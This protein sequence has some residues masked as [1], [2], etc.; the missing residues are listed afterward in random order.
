MV[1]PKWATPYFLL[2]KTE[3]AVYFEKK[4]SKIF[5]NFRMAALMCRSMI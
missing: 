1:L 2:H 4:S 5:S 3:I